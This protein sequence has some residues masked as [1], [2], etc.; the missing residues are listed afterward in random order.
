MGNE[1]QQKDQ[2]KLQPAPTQGQSA[3]AAPLFSITANSTRELAIKVAHAILVA[4]G[5]GT[6]PSNE[7]F[8]MVP[9][10]DKK[11]KVPTGEFYA[12]WN[13][14]DSK[15][16]TPGFSGVTLTTEEADMLP[17]TRGLPVAFSID[18]VLR[19]LTPAAAARTR[20]NERFAA[21]AEAARK[22]VDS[23]PMDDLL[24]RINRE[25]VAKG[26]APKKSIYD[27]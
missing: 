21:T 19:Q 3:P 6:I 7:H 17:T 14:D 16:I 22:K 18:L 15:V 11:T 27:E 9:K 4:S 5:K 8:V 24:E 13:M 10:V 23:V 2:Q 25:R 20:I 26:L 1:N 12:L